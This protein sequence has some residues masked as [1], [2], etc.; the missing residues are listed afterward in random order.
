[1]M[2]RDQLRKEGDFLFRHRS[3][4]PLIII[5]IG[6]AVFFYQQMNR[7][8]MFSDALGN[9]FWEYICFGVGI[10]GFLIRVHVVAYTPP[11]TSGRNT[12]EG[13]VA[14]V[15]NT[16]GLY[17]TIRHPLYLGNFFM[18]LGVAMLTE[19]LWFMVA[20]T[21]FYMLYYERIM[22]AEEAFLQEKFSGAYEEWS[23]KTNTILPNLSNYKGA[24]VSFQLK[25]VIK[26]EKNGILALFLLFWIFELIENYLQ[27]DA[28]YLEK[29][30]WLYG[31][32]A[33]L[34]YYVVVK[35]LRML[36]LM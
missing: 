14:D 29:S 24:E 36:K 26:K 32:V 7:D 35:V 12:K 13:Q 18:W 27:L 4:L 6:L 11:Q 17:S 19:N 28:F 25:K 9:N 33:T 34:L 5:I 23:S 22:Y 2:L 31:L 20:F 10:L 3:N 1:M 30:F 21:L 16:T 8:L 15:L